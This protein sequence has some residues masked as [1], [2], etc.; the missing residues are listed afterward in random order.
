M[1]VRKNKRK[2]PKGRQSRYGSESDKYSQQ[3]SGRM[4]KMMPQIE[5]SDSVTVYT[6]V[7]DPNSL[8]ESMSMSTAGVVKAKSKDRGKTKSKD[9]GGNDKNRKMWMRRNDSINS[10][11]RRVLDT[12]AR[13]QKQVRELATDSFYERSERSL[14]SGGGEK[15]KMRLMTTSGVLLFDGLVED[16]P[17]DRSLQSL[18]RKEREEMAC[19]YYNDQESDQLLT[20][21]NA[22]GTNFIKAHK[23]YD[24]IESGF[25]QAD[26]R[27][28]F[29]ESDEESENEDETRDV[30]VS[31]SQS[32]GEKETNRSKDSSS[33]G[34]TPDA[35]K[36]QETFEPSVEV[37]INERSP[38][39]KI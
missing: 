37:V 34:L 32:I 5:I 20:S 35:D 38:L 25:I 39:W 27:T 15:Q 3:S 19:Q 29:Y 31:K 12:E 13:I 28:K 24:P 22:P 16:I 1:R 21:K 4:G 14:G 2:E 10:Y 36:E 17:D 18:I 8:S 11:D 23:N 7:I 9:K 30:S 33:F 6:K 26:G